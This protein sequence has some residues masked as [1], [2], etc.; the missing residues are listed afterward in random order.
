MY[1]VRYRNERKGR[2]R[3]FDREQALLEA[4]GVFWALGYE[5]AALTNLQEAMGGISAPSFYAAFGSKE[6][7]FRE[8]VELYS[9]TLGAPMIRE[10]NR[11][12]TVRAAIEALLGNAVNAFTKP[13]LPRGCMLVMAAANVTPGNRNVRR[14]VRGLRARRTKAIQQRLQ[15]GMAEGELPSNLDRSAVANFYAIVIDGLA[16]R[17]RDG[18]SRKA[19]TAAANCAMA[20]WDKTVM[21]K[22]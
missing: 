5:G 14:Y 17:A 7:L 16:I 1:S 3:E 10:L 15:R 9:K 20:A 22:V 13:G 12:P 6:A 11:A 21:L 19:L 8:A 4:M 18:A 2:P